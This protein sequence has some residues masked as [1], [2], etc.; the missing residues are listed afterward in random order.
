MSDEHGDVIGGGGN[1]CA[2]KS[3]T[4]IQAKAVR[5]FM[6]KLNGQQPF[7]KTIK[8]AKIISAK[9]EFSNKESMN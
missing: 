1:Y 2:I 9:L 5:N 4:G 7:I 8:L 3:S 6:Y